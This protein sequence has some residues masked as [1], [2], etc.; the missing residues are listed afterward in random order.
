MTLIF[1]KMRSLLVED[2][3]GRAVDFVRWRR[4]NAL[5]DMQS[6]LPVLREWTSEYPLYVGEIPFVTGPKKVYLV[7]FASNS[8]LLRRYYSQFPVLHNLLE[9][10]HDLA[11][12]LTA[13]SLPVVCPLST[14]NSGTLIIYEEQL[15]S[16]S[17]FLSGWRVE[18]LVPDIFKRHYL[19]QLGQGLADF[20]RATCAWEQTHDPHA[21]LFGQRTATWYLRQFL[22]LSHAQ[23]PQASTQLQEVAVRIAS[24]LE[25]WIRSEQYKSVEALPKT[26]LH[27]DFTFKNVLF[28]HG[29][30]S[31]ILDLEL[32]YFGYRLDDIFITM[33][34]IKNKMVY[35]QISTN[36]L[37]REILA[38]YQSV[39]LL[40]TDELDLFDS[41]LSYFCVRKLWEILSHSRYPE[42]HID[43][44]S[45]QRIAEQAL[46]LVD[47]SS[48]HKL[49]Q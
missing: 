9:Y 41:A 47:S 29:Q 40:E 12:F 6:L 34:G 25:K 1:K 20:H 45:V 8:V 13:K 32:A 39:E 38:G 22:K 10:Q 16:L 36:V 19:R 4:I 23:F 11:G 42:N 24:C 43:L 21:K 5:T 37:V 33:Y 15:W 44:A 18:N 35:P 7:R 26:H 30:I 46:R 3:I 2:G 28:R 48:N 17:P 31:A 14:K 49:R 27:G